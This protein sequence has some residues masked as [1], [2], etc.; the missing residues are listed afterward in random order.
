[1]PIV[2]TDLAQKLSEQTNIVTNII[3][4]IEG[5]SHKFGAI[6]IKE[7][8]ALDMDKT[9]DSGLFFDTDILDPDSNAIINID[10]TTKNIT[11]QLSIDKGIEAVKS[12]TV[13][14]LDKDGL[15]SDIFTPGKTVDDVL[16]QKAQ[17]YLNFKGSTHPTD[18]L[19]IIEGV[20]GQYTFTGKGTCKLV[21][22]HASQLKR[23]EIFLSHKTKLDGA[24][25]SGSGAIDLSDASGLVI[26][27]ATVTELET[28][29][30]VGDEIIKYDGI[31]SNQLTGCTRQQ[32]GTVQPSSHDSGTEVTSF[33]RLQG[34]SIDLA[35]KLMLSTGGYGLSKST[36]A[37]EILS[38][39][40]TVE[41]AILFASK[42][43]ETELG[44]T[45]GDHV[46]ITGSDSNN[47]TTTISSFGL[48]NED[49]SYI[50]V[51]DALTAEDEQTATVKFKSKYD[52]LQEGA[53]M[54][55]DQVDISK[56]L[57]WLSTF[58]GNFPDL[59]FYLEEELIIDEFIN[60]E[61]YRPCNLYSV[62]GARSS[63]KMTLPPLSDL[64][65]KTL[66]SSNVMDPSSINVHRSLN[67]YHYNSLV[68]KYNTRATD[69]SKYL[70]G[71]V[72]I[73]NDSLTR[74]GAGKK[75]FKIE[76]QGLRDNSI[77]T[78]ALDINSTRF[79]DRY[80][81]AA[82]SFSITTF[83]SNIT[84]EVGDI[85]VVDGLNIYDST[86]GSRAFTPKQFE[87]INKSISIG[88]AK[89]KLDLLS[90]TYGLDGRYG[91]V[92]PSSKIDSGATTTNI[93]LKVSY[94]YTG[95]EEEKWEPHIGTNVRVYNSDF[96]FNETVVL[97]G[98]DSS[99]PHTAIVSPA[100]SSPPS[101]DFIFDSPLY[102]DGTSDAM[103]MMKDMYLFVN[104]TLDI[105]GVTDSSTFTVSVSDAAK[106]FADATIEVHNS[107]YT[108]AEEAVVDSVVG[109]TVTLKTA[110][111]FT[112][113]TD[114]K[115]N[116]VGFA[117][118]SGK[119]YRII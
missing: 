114:H 112:P 42:N 78:Q 56:H 9:F 13:D 33:Y 25:A 39:T 74:I 4:E 92:S 60:K 30:K 66:D 11:S 36:T 71:K 12:F 96:S 109:T 58:S 115:I 15:L 57:Y 17:V 10:G 107:T 65:T 117:S 88:S 82:E 102:D 7:E 6:D 20:I 93:P 77:T 55:P 16:G 40:L 63:V 45:V 91:V 116:L 110:L 75:V 48:I 106:L 31:S 84:I 18:S 34:N 105:T 28:Y 89:I 87:V 68:Y 108:E 101:E 67:K 5:F 79:L 90:T 24:L 35:L 99:S 51:A 43:I 62:P 86:S 47:I 111:S 19:L 80:K 23:Q 32:F 95:K 14:M 64:Y 52:V 41:N 72:V 81:F 103:A 44:L 94:G 1:M 113:T 22:D 27:D 8:L 29:V 38:S 59:D 85:V 53:G 100:L 98:F 69:L 76:S 50:V 54:L 26:P 3:L 61:L 119:P 37:F 83:F 97:T 70:N 104:P 46:Q 49:Y 21:I 2:L 73:N 118:D